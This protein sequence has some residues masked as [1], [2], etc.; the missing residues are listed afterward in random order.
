MYECIHI[1]GT[2]VEDLGKNVCIEQGKCAFAVWVCILTEEYMA[3]C[4]CYTG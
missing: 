2:R 4:V 3:G 1:L